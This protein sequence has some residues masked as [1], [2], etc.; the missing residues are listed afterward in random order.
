MHFGGG[1]K[2]PYDDELAKLH[3]EQHH[4]GRRDHLSGFQQGQLAPIL[5]LIAIVLVLSGLV[6][7]LR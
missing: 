4:K 6:A 2:L 7:V 3:M 5:I 1:N